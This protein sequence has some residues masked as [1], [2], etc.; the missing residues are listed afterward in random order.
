MHSFHVNADCLCAQRQIA[1]GAHRITERR[2][3]DA[4]QQEHAGSDEDERE[5]E[6]ERELVERN[7]R[8]D[9]EHGRLENT[10]ISRAVSL[11]KFTENLAEADEPDADAQTSAST[12]TLLPGSDIVRQ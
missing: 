3:Q 6:E 12:M 2:K 8:P 11:E 1:A 7:A 9:A 10:A 5:Q 4:P